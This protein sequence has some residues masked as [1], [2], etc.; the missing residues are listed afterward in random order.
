MTHGMV[1]QK[2]DPRP[3]HLN[4]VI[5]AI[6]DCGIMD[7][8][9][10]KWISPKGMK[11]SVADATAGGEEPLVNEH[12]YLPYALLI[13]GMAISVLVWFLEM[14]GRDIALKTIYATKLGLNTLCWNLKTACHWLVRRAKL[15]KSACGY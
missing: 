3:R 15:L 14:A 10:S 9:F 7:R 5:D 1:F 11:D 4:P 8:F 13:G 2:Y 6:R 12:F